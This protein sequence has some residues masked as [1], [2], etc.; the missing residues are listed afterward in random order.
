[1]CAMVA[2]YKQIKGPPGTGKTEVLATIVVNWVRQMKSY[3]SKCRCNSIFS[4]L[5]VSWS[6]EK[7]SDVPANTV[8]IAVCCGTNAGLENSVKAILKKSLK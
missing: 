2:I 4:S 7:Q 8:K 3:D 5:P 6:R 1:M